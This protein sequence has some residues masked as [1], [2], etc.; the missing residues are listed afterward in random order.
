M[1]SIPNRPTVDAVP[2]LDGKTINCGCCGEPLAYRIGPATPGYLDAVGQNGG[3]A[4]PLYHFRGYAP[5]EHGV[6][7]MPDRA[8]G[9]RDHGH[10]RPMVDTIRV[11]GRAPQ[12]GLTRLGLGSTLVVGW[13]YPRDGV[14]YVACWRA[15]RCGRVN[16]VNA[17]NARH[18][19]AKRRL[20]VLE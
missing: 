19:L 5:G 3:G 11:E 7:Q 17:S 1:A 18:S 15:G 10:R 8:K 4:Y 13:G 12:P 20:P 9:R 16:V 14:R 2:S 6:W